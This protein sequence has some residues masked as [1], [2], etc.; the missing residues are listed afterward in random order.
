MG[1]WTI[2]LMIFTTFWPLCNACVPMLHIRNRIDETR[3]VE[4]FV[5]MNYTDTDICNSN[6]VRSYSAPRGGEASFNRGRCEL[7][8]VTA[9]LKIPITPPI[10]ITIIDIPSLT[11]PGNEEQCKTYV[12]T[13]WNPNL[14]KILYVKR[15][16]TTNECFI[17][18]DP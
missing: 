15:N 9:K 16:D 4:G 7:L 6:T 18:T 5:V 11:I 2:I 8:W 10:D 13:N 1:M 12:E 17:T 14:S 3:Q